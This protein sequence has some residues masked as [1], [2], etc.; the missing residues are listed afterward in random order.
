[1]APGSGRGNATLTLTVE[2]NT[3]PDDARTA[4]VI[5]NGVPYRVTQNRFI[6]SYMVNPTSLD[7]AAGGGNVRITLMTSDTC[8][9]TAAA[10]ESWIRVLTPS[11]TGSAV[12]SVDLESHS[13]N[14][15]RRGFLTIAGLR[16]DVLQRRN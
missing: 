5:V 11:G 4:T 13:T 15:D 14:V 6:C 12:I 9:W 10:S 3:R 7:Q 8:P 16:V 2:Q 1:M